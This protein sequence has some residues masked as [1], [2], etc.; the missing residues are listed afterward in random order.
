M[1]TPAL[2]K[3]TTPVDAEI[4]LDVNRVV[5][6]HAEAAKAAEPERSLETAKP[7]A[8]KAKGNKKYWNA[9]K[10]QWELRGEVDV[11]TGVTDRGRKIEADPRIATLADV[12]ASDTNKAIAD[13]AKRDAAKNAAK[14]EAHSITTPVS[15]TPST[16]V[17]QDTKNAAERAGLTK[18]E[19]EAKTTVV[20]PREK[21]KQLTPEEEALHTKNKARITEIEGIVAEQAKQTTTIGEKMAEALALHKDPDKNLTEEQKKAKLAKQAADP[22]VQRIVRARLGNDGE[23]TTEIVERAE[24]D[25]ML[26]EGADVKSAVDKRLEDRRQANRRGP[27]RMTQADALKAGIESAAA[28]NAPSRRHRGGDPRGTGVN[29]LAPITTPVD[30]LDAEIELKIP[31]VSETDYT[32]AER[33]QARVAQAKWKQEQYNKKGVDRRAAPGE[34]VLEQQDAEEWKETA[35]RAKHGD[36]AAQE[37]INKGR[38]QWR[39]EQEGKRSG[40]M[41]ERAE[42][43]LET[44][45][46]QG[47]KA[48]GASVPLAIRAQPADYNPETV[49][50]EARSSVD[51]IVG[52]QKARILKRIAFL[53]DSLK[54]GGQPIW[55]A[56][57]SLADAERQLKGLDPSPRTARPTSALPPRKAI[58][59]EGKRAPRPLAGGIKPIERRGAPGP[60]LGPVGER[61]IKTS[62][63]VNVGDV[64]PGERRR[65]GGRRV[66]NTPVGPAMTVLPEERRILDQ[67]IESGEQRK[68]QATAEGRS[69]TVRGN[70]RNLPDRRTSGTE[71]RTVQGQ[72][73]TGGSGG[74]TFDP[75]TS[76]AAQVSTP[77]QN[78]ATTEGWWTGAKKSVNRIFDVMGKAKA[79]LTSPMIDRVAENARKT[80]VKEGLLR[81][82]GKG[83]VNVGIGAAVLG[84]AFAATDAIASVFNVE[85]AGRSQRDKIRDAAETALETGMD[86]AVGVTE[87]TIATKAAAAAGPGGVPFTIAANVV[88]PIG[89]MAGTAAAVGSVAGKTKHQW[90]SQVQ[91]EISE[92][93]VMDAKYGTIERA[94]QTRRNRNR[95]ISLDDTETIMQRWDD[96]A[97]AKRTKRINDAKKPGRRPRGV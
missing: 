77:G 3:V 55:R 16:V 59:E 22:S 72:G 43:Q 83:T 6:Q 13:A 91:K 57:Q 44:A 41:L 2:P 26:K 21:K 15:T 8:K 35:E 66:V 80:Y 34:T 62:P 49:L 52:N 31:E 81:K 27:G 64:A 92:K 84:T 71:R 23:H 10:G 96:E 14:I 95:K 37:A 54:P 89:V 85:G 4:P 45:Q 70:E 18:A 40:D 28:K 51:P 30:V 65:A 38:R 20:A 75:A 79:T 94:T 29:P 78:K 87:F 32:L 82:A 48:E 39:G 68:H 97:K 5:T 76:E 36:D 93:A 12:D 46:R 25:L 50:S 88:L 19:L 73:P 58:G 24:I 9:Q 63:Y 53:K 47:V 17:L 1:T 60:H 42:A 90:D 11:L 33:E 7:K 74:R 61:P 69:T 56:H 67:Y 86:T